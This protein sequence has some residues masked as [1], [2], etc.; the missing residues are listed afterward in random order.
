MR[1]KLLVLAAASISAVA[2]LLYFLRPPRQ[3]RAIQ[4]SLSSVVD[5]YRKII[6]L[7]DGA[8]ALDETAHA[9]CNLA[10]QALFWHKQRA[11]DHIAATFEEP[12][13]RALHVRLLVRYLNEDRGLH[14]ADKLA[15][16][17]LVS[18]LAEG[19]TANLR[20]L[21]D[22]LQSIQLAYR[23][24]V[25]RIFSQFAT[26]GGSATREK[27]DSYVAVLRKQ[28]SREAILGEFGDLSTGEPSSGTRGGYGGKEVFGSEFPPKSVALT[29]DDGPHPKYTE[30]VLAI[31]RKYGLKACFFELGSLVGKTDDSGGIKLLRGADISRK[32]VEAGH[33]IANHSYSH[34]SLT[35]LPETERNAEID[36]TSAILEKVSGRKLELFRAPYGARNQAIIERITSEGMRSIMWNTDAEDWA[37]PIPESIAMRILHQLNQHPKGVILLHDIHQQSVLALSPVIEELMRQNY[38][39]LEFDK[40][41][42]VKSGAPAGAERAAPELV[43]AA[44]VS[45]VP[46]KLY[47]DSWAVIIGVNDYRHWPKLKYAVN[48]ANGMEEVLVN[49][50]GFQRD[51]ITK[52]LDGD[53]TRQRI[54]QVMGDE[55]SDNRKVQRED[56]VFFFFA[57]HGAT[58]ALDDGRQVG[59]IVPVD[60]DQSNYYSTAIS[61]TTLRETADLIP[62]KHIYFV[63]DS[64]YS[65]LAMT[66]GAAGF[67]KDRSYLEEVTRR[68]ARQIL[69]AGGAEQQVADDGPN[70]HSVF[71]WALLQGLEGQA[72]LD[73]NGVI[74]ASELGAYVSP[75]VSSF[76]RQTPSV[77]NLVGSEGGEFVFELQPQPLTSASAQFD[78]QSLQLNRQLASLQDQIAAKQGELLRLQQSIQAQSAKLPGGEASRSAA[79]PPSTTALAYDLDRQGQQFYREKNYDW[80]LRKFHEAVALKPGDALLLNNLGF[81][82]YVMGRYDEALKYLQKTLAVGSPRKEAHLNIAD[83]YLK[84]GRRAEAKQHYEQFLALNPNSP[85]AEDVRR[86]VQGLSAP[87]VPA[88]K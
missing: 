80:A 26:R 68:T 11:L 60:A 64:C 70:G 55:L 63:M 40:G 65:G 66:R 56:R 71:T 44:P 88:V 59:F 79:P 53:A 69:T 75:I 29:F 2:A 36:Q 28:Y 27:W 43:A 15:F 5:D 52:L 9:R 13:T 30:Q 57:G 47:R 62:A 50:F 84:L 35:K 51:H 58:R 14:D 12:S 38:T 22:N 48:D 4:T 34:P 1:W 61:M 77:G 67:S 82:C 73:G 81:V 32:V 49:R 17:D 72:D 16:L 41:D 86:I 78:S 31:L 74:T 46:R 10:G 7:M 37:D 83:L 54:M 76:A 39:F 24:E 8:D 85:H 6:V 3:D 18:Q 25:A 33:L 45:D 19:G 23:E 20:P 42:F 87:Q 21:L